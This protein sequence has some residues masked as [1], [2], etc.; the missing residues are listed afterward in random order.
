MRATVP[1]D[2]G[3]ELLPPDGGLVG[4]S[5]AGDKLGEMAFVKRHADGRATLILPNALEAPVSRTF[6]RTLREAGWY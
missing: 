3:P 1:V 2:G 5:I 4:E 6:A